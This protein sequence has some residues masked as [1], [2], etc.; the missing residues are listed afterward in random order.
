MKLS[1]PAAFFIIFSFC[2]F[3]CEGGEKT[4]LS[5]SVAIA[6]TLE[7]EAY[8]EI[9]VSST[10][11]IH[12]GMI[13]VRYTCDGEDSAP[14]LLWKNLP[15]STESLALIC[16]DPDAPGG[17]WV[18]W[19][20]Y[21]ISPADTSLSMIEADSSSEFVR[22]ENSWGKLGYG[23]PCPPSGTHRYFFQLYALD[24]ELELEEGATREEVLKAM[25]GH[26]LGYG[27]IM[28]KYHRQN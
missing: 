11:F 7:G 4:E 8:E 28:G 18:H 24:C 22:G 9:R 26:V 1:I 23:G 14:E 19:V 2:A 27:E 17:T 25:K 16:D 13:P 5:H 6:D 10:A 15:D 3:A 20:V 21:N 12:E